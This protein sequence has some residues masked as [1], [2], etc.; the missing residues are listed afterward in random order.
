MAPDLNLLFHP[1]KKNGVVVKPAGSPTKKKVARPPPPKSVE[2]A[3]VQEE[4]P[5][6]PDGVYQEFKVMSVDAQGWHYDYMKFDDRRKVD[7]RQWQEPVKMNRKEVRRR[8][9]GSE[10]SGPQAVGP[11]LGPDGKPV[12]GMD[13]RMVMV[14]AEGRPIHNTQ[15]NRG[16]DGG[17]GGRGRGGRKF[18]KKTRQVFLVPD[19]VRQLRREERYPWVLEDASG[20][21]SWLGSMEEV[22]KSETHA[23][24]IPSPNSVFNFMPIHRWYKYHKKPSHKVMDLEEAEALV[25]PFR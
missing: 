3:P 24:L 25:S 22:S 21:E 1:K 6:L 14:D 20:T 13:G 8:D 10:S 18:Q 23:I 5:K 11:M 15:N 12:I 9:D 7:P 17:R 19:E 2:P 4:R 16:Q